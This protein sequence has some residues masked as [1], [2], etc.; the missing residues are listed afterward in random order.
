MKNNFSA[1]KNLI[2]VI[3]SAL[4]LV[5][6]TFAWYAV[7]N[8]SA[9][10]VFT[11]KV[12]GSTLS[13]TYHESDDNGVTYRVLE[14]DLEMKNMVEG[15]KK[16]YRIDVKTFPDV[17]IKLVMSFENL[18][19]TN[20]L[21]PYVY[22]DYKIV[23]QSSGEEIESKTSLKMSEYTVSNVFAKDISDFQNEGNNDF[24][25]YYDVYVITG[26]DVVSG[27][28]ELGDVKIQGQQVG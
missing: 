5:A 27:A 11:G 13:V 2:L 10:S 18:V 1:I 22:F 12:N 4:T 24:S 26:E 25:I 9:L 7:T 20:D 21:L 17:P 3:A 23:C 8:Q 6:V 16:M 15:Q 19:S 14:D 28:A